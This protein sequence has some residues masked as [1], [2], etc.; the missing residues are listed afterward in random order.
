MSRAFLWFNAAVIGAIGLAYLY[1]P[2]LLLGQYDLSVQ[3]VGLDNMMRATYGGVFV[4]V[5]VI[6]GIGAAHPPRQRDA[7][8]LATL[9]MGGLALGRV[10]S[11]ISVG[12]PPSGLLPLLGYEA[13]AAGLALVLGRR[14][15][16]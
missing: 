10:A 14:A 11:M 1:G 3:D 15:A 9:F 12:L 7:L 5:A 6:F 4:A 16:V 13:I 2:N 8:M